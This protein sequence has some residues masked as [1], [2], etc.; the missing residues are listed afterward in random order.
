M[1]EPLTAQGRSWPVSVYR[2]IKHSPM[3]NIFCIFAFLYYASSAWAQ[4]STCG[5][6][7]DNTIRVPTDYAK[8]SEPAFNGA[9]FAP[10]NVVGG[11]FTDGL[12]SCP[13]TQLSYGNSV[14]VRHEYSN[15]SAINEDDTLI[16]LL[17]STGRWF[18]ADLH[19][20]VIV[21]KGNVPWT[22]G[23]GARWDTTSPL[24][25]Y[26]VNADSKVHKATIPSNYASC[27]PSC[28]MTSTVLHDFS[29]SYAVYGVDGMNLG[30]GEGDM[31]PQAPNL[32]VL[33]GI[34]AGG[35]PVGG[36]QCTS[37]I[38]DIFTYNVATD[39]VG[40]KLSLSSNIRVPSGPQAGQSV[41]TQFDNAQ[42]TPDG[43]I[44]IDWDAA[45]TAPCTSGPC[46]VGF[47]LYNTSM[48]YVR[49]LFWPGSAHSKEMYYKGKSYF[50]FYDGYGFVCPSQGLAAEDINSGTATCIFNQFLPWDASIHV[51]GSEDGSGWVVTDHVD[52]EASG[53]GS[54]PL[55]SNWNANVS[56]AGVPGG[57]YGYWGVHTGEEILVRVDGSSIYRMTW[58]R[59]RAGGSSYWKTPRS[60]ISRD[61]KYVVYDSDYGQ[62]LN[63]PSADYTDVFLL[64]TGLGQSSNASLQPPL[65][66]SISVIQ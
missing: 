11:T 24:V 31:Q 22:G 32:L 12:S 19:G 26:Y 16:E 45:G 62:G 47:E 1:L 49:T 54:Y 5:L 36:C 46:Y 29:R 59:S 2:A 41:T 10:P 23:I 15:M 3:K 25:L 60:T 53:A 28:T 7:D 43:Q 61:A 42:L 52:Y 55:A 13:I 66:L 27:K 65:N 21:P 38:L 50:V 18:I 56:P 14:A 48:Q 35:T 51:G 64:G 34:E 8:S 39:A 33:C 6:P 37:C 20:S 57:G 30:G 17:D 58:N 4:A 63:I 9:F 44:V 40:P